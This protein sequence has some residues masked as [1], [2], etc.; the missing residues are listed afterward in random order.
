MIYV[1]FYQEISNI[2][3]QHID[4]SQTARK[5]DG[6]EVPAHQANLLPVAIMIENE[7]DSRPPAGLVEAKLVYEVLS[8]GEITRFLAIYDLTEDLDRIGPVRSARPYYIQI[9]KEYDA[10]YVHCGGSP[11]ALAQL[12]HEDE[13]VDLNEYFGFN[14][15]YFWRDKGKLAPHNLYT[16]TQLLQSA[17]DHYR[18]TD[19]VSDF[20]SWLY[21]SKPA[22]TQQPEQRIVI[23]YSQ[24]STYQVTWQY[25]PEVNLYQRWQDNRQHTDELGQ[26]VAADNVVILFAQTQVIDEVGRRKIDLVGSGRVLVFRDGQVIEGTWQKL[27][28]WHRTTFFDS[29][30]QEIV[31]NQGQTWIQI[32]PQE[33]VVTY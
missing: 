13:I 19:D 20:T 7:K 8:E 24:S 33:L 3:F 11:T 5:L 25:Q 10:L 12:K 21:K 26:G 32:V 17:K 31:L 4:T 9:A 14:S 6:V 1:W 15:G 27:E 18:L 23:P 29:N 28:A 16:S 2:R 30:Q 22:Q